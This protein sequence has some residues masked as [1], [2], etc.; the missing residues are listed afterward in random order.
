LVAVEAGVEV[1]ARGG[2]E[3]LRAKSTALTELVIAL[4][5][6]WLEP[7]GFTL[8][9]PADPARRGGH[10]A[11]RHPDAWRIDRTLIERANVVPDFRAPDRIRLTPVAAYSRFTEVWDAMDRL[12]GL[13][14]RGDHRAFAA[15]AARSRVT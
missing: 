2:I 10:V 5:R 6:A 9:S 12:R 13:V 8:G 15:P 7:L 1:L 11:L 4:W 14:E 3:A